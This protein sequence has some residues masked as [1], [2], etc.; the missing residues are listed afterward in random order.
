VTDFLDFYVGSYHWPTFN[1][2][3]VAIVCGVGLL[4]VESVLARGEAKTT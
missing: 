3:D 4:L 1:V 2:A